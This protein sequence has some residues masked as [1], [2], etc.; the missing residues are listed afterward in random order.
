MD[1]LARPKVAVTDLIPAFEKFTKAQ[2]STRN[3]AS[4]D[5]YVWRVYV[6]IVAISPGRRLPSQKYT[7]TVA[8]S[9]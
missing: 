7:F 9:G 4:A 1:E 2:S 6:G 3:P 8:Q 5:D